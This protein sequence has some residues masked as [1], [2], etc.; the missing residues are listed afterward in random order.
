MTM[1]RKAADK[2]IAGQLIYLRCRIDTKH[3]VFK[4]GI[5]SNKMKNIFKVMNR[6]T[7]I[8][9]VTTKSYLERWGWKKNL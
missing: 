1:N 7:R 2:L 9:C 8:E 3:D 6:K 4:K 5:L